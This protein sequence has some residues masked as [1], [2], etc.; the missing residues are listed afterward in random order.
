MS[1][2]VAFRTDVAGE[3]VA[4]DHVGGAVVD[5][6][7]FDVADEADR[8]ALEQAMRLAR[9]LVALVGFFAD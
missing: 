1:P 8:C 9:E 6:A 2:S 3:A 7:P 5:F 4:D